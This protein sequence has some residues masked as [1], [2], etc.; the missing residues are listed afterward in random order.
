MEKITKCTQ[1]KF[2]K[3][4]PDPDF[5]DSFNYDDVAVVCLKKNNSNQDINSKYLVDRQKYA[6]I[7]CSCRPYEIEKE[8]DIPNWCPLELI[9]KID[10]F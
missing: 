3:V 2:S 10:N 9:T 5:S 1:C 4:I 7:T 8:S 6:I